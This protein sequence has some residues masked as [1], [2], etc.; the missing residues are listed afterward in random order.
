[1]KKINI[2]LL[3][4]ILTFSVKGVALAQRSSEPSESPRSTATSKPTS[5]QSATPKPSA[6]PK[7]SFKVTS[8]SDDELKTAVKKSDDA[9]KSYKAAKTADKLA[10]AKT[11][12]NEIIDERI[13]TLNN[14]LSKDFTGL[15]AED[16]LAIQTDVANVIDALSAIKVKITAATTVDEVKTAV[17]SVYSMKIMAVILP[18]VHAMKALYQSSLTLANL[19]L[20]SSK[21]SAK[22]A[23]MTAA[24]YDTVAFTTS[25]NDYNSKLKE[26]STLISKSKTS[27]AAISATDP[28]VAQSS[29][30]TIKSNIQSIRADF[31]AARADLK[32]IKAIILAPKLS[33]SSLSPSAS[34]SSANTARPTVS[35]SPVTN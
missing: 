14:F 8:V 28:T 4:V 21:I 12:G 13:A 11:V 6:T 3:S 24:N 7:S 16:T 5:S 18:K 33:T 34:A 9:W 2:I 19:E 15:S 25:F 30:A 35:G 1:M 32:A 29:I 23:E 27:I 26:A 20:I 10:K 31:I 17:A 22:L